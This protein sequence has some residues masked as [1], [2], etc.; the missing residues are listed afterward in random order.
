VIDEVSKLEAHP[1]EMVRRYVDIKVTAWQSELILSGFLRFSS[2]SDYLFVELTYFILPPPKGEYYAIHRFNRRPTPHELFRLVL[3]SLKAMPLLWLKAPVRVATWL[4]RPIDRARREQQVE[5]EIRENRRF[6]FGAL[7]SI[8]EAGADDEYAKYFQQMDVEQLYKVID[9]HLFRV[10]W[11]FL[12]D[13]GVDTSQ[14]ERS[15][16]AIINKGNWI[17]GNKNVNV[18]MDHSAIFDAS[19]SGDSG[20]Q[21][22]SP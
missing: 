19:G 3:D 17:V 6:D 5:Q 10:I 4:A 12:K 9:Q 18:A 16:Q 7:G 8:R 14:L 13:K 22:S 1:Q 15:I 21:Q 11:K 20:G 2:T